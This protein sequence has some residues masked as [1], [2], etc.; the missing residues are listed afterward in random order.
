MKFYMHPVST[1][2]RPIRLLMAEK[3]LKADEVLVDLMTGAHYQEPYASLNPNKLVRL[4]VRRNGAEIAVPVNVR[5]TE[6]DQMGI[7]GIAPESRYA[8]A[9][10]VPGTEESI[11]LRKRRNSSARWRG[12]ISAITWPE[13]TSSA[14]YRFVVPLR[15]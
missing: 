8:I 13:A 6:R 7:I 3:G 9:Q 11:R 14:A 5:A 10:V 1:T 12:V 4:T 2:C 15:T